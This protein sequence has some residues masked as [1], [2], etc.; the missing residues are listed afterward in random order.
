MTMTTTL[1]PAATMVACTILGCGFRMPEFRAMVPSIDAMQRLDGTDG[2][3]APIAELKI[4]E[5]IVCPRC[6]RKIAAAV[7]GVKFF[8]LTG[9]RDQIARRLK[10]RADRDVA[11]K[12]AREAD[13]KARYE[14]V[15]A[16]R[17]AGLKTAIGKFAGLNPKEGVKT[18]G[19]D[20]R[21]LVGAAA[22][23]VVHKAITKI[24]E[25]E[26]E[27]IRLLEAG[28]IAARL[29]DQAHRDKIVA[30]NAEM[31]AAVCGRR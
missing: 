27:R 20:G 24:A 5:H 14:V 30:R 3:L 8:Y 9:T 17:K 19:R 22:N 6:A 16:E 18:E 13:R 31:T 21:K 7:P 4:A 12:A 10:A 28:K 1:E 26:S 11:M 29:K 25:E 2:R 23:A 15:K